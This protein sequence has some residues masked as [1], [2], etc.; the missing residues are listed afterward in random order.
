MKLGNHVF[1]YLIAAGTFV[2]AGGAQ[3][4]E[5]GANA[6]A[7]SST[8]QDVAPPK[9]NALPTLDQMLQQQTLHCQPWKPE[10]SSASPSSGA[11]ERA[12]VGP[13][14]TGVGGTDD[15]V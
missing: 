7:S 6:S 11:T 4:L 2:L 15:H 8:A 9:K 1:R 14:W 12:G 13:V 5:N 10:S 3:A